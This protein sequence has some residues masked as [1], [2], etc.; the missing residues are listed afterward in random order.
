MSVVLLLLCGCAAD[1][2]E[3]DRVDTLPVTGGECTASWWL[4]PLVKDVPANAAAIARSALETAVVTDS[5]REEWQTV[6]DESD[7]SDRELPPDRLEGR[8]HIEVVRE[9]VRVELDA[10][11]YPDAP[12]RLIEV[13]SS[14]N[15]S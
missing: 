14:L 7:S 9:H 13:Y 12:T 10:A 4:E 8:A 1:R 6:V 15:C 3:P 2:G 11:G 5:A